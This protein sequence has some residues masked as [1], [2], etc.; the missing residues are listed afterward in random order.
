MVYIPLIGG[1]FVTATALAYLVFIAIF[2]RGTAAIIAI[3]VSH[4]N[5]TDHTQC[6]RRAPRPQT[7]LYRRRSCPS[8]ATFGDDV[9]SNLADRGTKN[10]RWYPG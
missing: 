6:N 2:G 4:R 3:A 7:P 1:L 8:C 10:F 5:D 9:Q